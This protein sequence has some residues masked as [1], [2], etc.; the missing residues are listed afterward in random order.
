MTEATEAIGPIGER[1]A[2]SEINARDTIDEID[3][4]ISLAEKL[5]TCVLK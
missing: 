3:D 2:V 5:R 4:R 1:I